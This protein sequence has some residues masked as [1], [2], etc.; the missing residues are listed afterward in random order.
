MNLDGKKVLVVGLGRSGAAAA[1]LCAARGARVTVTDVREAAA[2]PLG[3]N[4]PPEV[5]R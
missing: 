2:L 1:R 3:D 5:T 4:L